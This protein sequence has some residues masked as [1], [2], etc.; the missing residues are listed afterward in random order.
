[1]KPTYLMLLFFVLLAAY[2]CDKPDP[3]ITYPVTYENKLNILRDSDF[4][5]QPG[6]RYSL[7]AYLPEGTSISV[8]C[9]PTEGNEWGGAGFLTPDRSGYKYTDY[10][11]ESL[12]FKA[13]G[14]DEYVNVDVIFG[15]TPTC[16]DLFI[17]ENNSSLI[18]RKKSVRN[19]E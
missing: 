7:A 5:L 9:K 14:E 17:Y 11:P 12:E 6:T 18:K 15:S 8:V 10:Y 3:V 19:F 13:R 4:V 1:M 2:S 16:I